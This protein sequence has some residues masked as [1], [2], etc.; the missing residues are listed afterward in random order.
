MIYSDPN[1][2]TDVLDNDDFRED[3][4]IGPKTS[5]FTNFINSD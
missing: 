3:G 5:H 1:T 2:W 4:L